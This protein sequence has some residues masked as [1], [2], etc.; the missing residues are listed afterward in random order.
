MEIKKRNKRKMRGLLCIENAEGKYEPINDD[1]VV[2]VH[3]ESEEER[4]RFIKLMQS[5]PIIGILQD[6]CEE[7]KKAAAAYNNGYNAALNDY[8]NLLG[9]IEDIKT[10]IKESMDDCATTSIYTRLGFD[11]ALNIINRHTSGK[12]GVK[13]D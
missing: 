5:D 1:H 8:K 13:R 4:E 6:P 7:C 12:E 9:A 10:E 2:E 3:L 11:T